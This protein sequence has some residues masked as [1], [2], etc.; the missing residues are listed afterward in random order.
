M[1]M[2]LNTKHWKFYENADNWNFVNNDVI[3]TTS[4]NN[5]IKTLLIM[6]KETILITNII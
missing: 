3:E 5:E 2:K 4:K 1:G 6:I